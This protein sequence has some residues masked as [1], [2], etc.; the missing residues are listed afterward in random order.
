MVSSSKGELLKELFMRLTAAGV[1]EVS[2]A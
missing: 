1:S 2:S